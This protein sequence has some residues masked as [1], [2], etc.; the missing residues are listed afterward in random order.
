MDLFG[1]PRFLYASFLDPAS[2]FTAGAAATSEATAENLLLAESLD[3]RLPR[4]YLHD[5]CHG[6]KDPYKQQKLFHDL[7]S[8]LLLIFCL[9]GR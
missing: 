4:Q 2:P 1:P 8:L 9:S 3:G 5:Q 6:V 7:I